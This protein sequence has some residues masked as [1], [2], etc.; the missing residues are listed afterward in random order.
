MSDTGQ[1]GWRQ[2]GRHALTFV[3]ITVFLDTV[4]FG[5]LIP[6]LPELL[7]TL[8]GTT[9]AQAAGYGGAMMFVFALMQFFFAPVLG[10]LSDRFGRRP[11]LLASLGVLAADYLIM[12]LAPTLFWLFV[13][14]ALAGGAAATFAT[15]NAY[16]SDITSEDERAGRFGLISAAWGIGFVLGPALGGLLGEFGLRVPFF[17]AAGLTAANL[18][19]GAIVLPETL[20]PERRRPFV[21]ARANPVGALRAVGAYAPLP[22]LFVALVC[23]FVAHDVNPSTWTYYVLHKFDW[24]KAEVGL[25]LAAVGLASALVSGTLVR[26]I[27]KR[28]GEAGAAYLGFGLCALGMTLQGLA[29][30]GW[31]MYPGI[32]LVAFMGLVMP[33]LRSLMSRQVPEDAQGELQGAIASVIGLTTIFAPVL[34]TQTFRAFSVADAPVYLPGAPF[35]LAAVLMVLAASVVATALRRS[36]APAGI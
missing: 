18:L 16:I 25:A 27:V 15:V 23:Y 4:A 6:V 5:I 24:S 12:G 10:N 8:A 7:A 30:A 9:I 17:V 22:A 33:S 34:M 21:F 11:V 20:A 29:T 35:L 36:T 3:L 28:L 13:G 2:P 32:A 31:M 26:P 19:Y 14:R 1:G